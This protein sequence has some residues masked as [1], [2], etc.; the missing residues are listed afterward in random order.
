MNSSKGSSTEAKFCRVKCSR[1]KPS[2]TLG[3]L[4]VRIETAIEALLQGQTPDA[5]YRGE[6][7]DAVQTKVLKRRGKKGDPRVVVKMSNIETAALGRS[8]DFATSNAR[9]EKQAKDRAA[10]LEEF[11]SVDM[12]DST[13]ETEL[14]TTGDPGINEPKDGNVDQRGEVP[15]SVSRVRPAQSQSEVNGSIGGEKSWVERGG[16]TPEMLQKRL[17]G[18]KRAEERELVRNAARRAVVFGLSNNRS[19]TRNEQVRYQAG[20]MRRCEALMNGK[21]VEPSFAKGDWCIRWRED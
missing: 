7:N 3:S 14:E 4:N 16:E 9:R 1:N 10:D 11:Q 18:Q 13:S 21:V 5:V 17:E 2:S 20:E 6:Q 19:F 12:V 8:L 15:F